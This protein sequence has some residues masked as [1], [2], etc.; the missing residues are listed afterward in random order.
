MAGK[1]R[2]KTLRPLIYLTFG[3]I[4]ALDVAKYYSFQGRMTGRRIQTAQGTSGS[5]WG[6]G[7]ALEER[8][9]LGGEGQPWRYAFVF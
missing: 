5:V 7:T 8:D 1:A 9:S 3:L 2:S 4:C 6:R